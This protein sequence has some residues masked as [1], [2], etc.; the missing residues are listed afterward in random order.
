MCNVEAGLQAEWRGFVLSL[1]SKQS[2]CRRF[3]F[4]S[5]LRHNFQQNE[6]E[7]KSLLYKLHL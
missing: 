7:I 3:N 6:Q 2:R 1:F 4:V 5:L